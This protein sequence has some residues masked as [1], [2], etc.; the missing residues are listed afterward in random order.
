MSIVLSFRVE[1]VCPDDET[2]EEKKRRQEAE[3]KKNLPP[4]ALELAQSFRAL[5]KLMRTSREIW[6]KANRRMEDYTAKQM[7]L[8]K[9]RNGFSFVVP[10]QFSRFFVQLSENCDKSLGK[11]CRMINKNA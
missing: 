11:S 8:Y 6:E 7:R 10:L 5:D 9:V 3:A 1:L 4:A 2:E